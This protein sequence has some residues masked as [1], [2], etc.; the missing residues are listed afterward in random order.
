MH[1]LVCS[2]Y[3]RPG[4]TGWALLDSIA[5]DVLLDFAYIE[6]TKGMSPE[7]VEDINKQLKAL[8]PPSKTSMVEVELSD[9]RVIE[10]SEARLA[11]IREKH[12]A[13]SSRPRK[14]Q[15]VA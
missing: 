15:E 12:A 8:D 6:L 10:V 11:E 3:A 4:Q 2:G 5:L 13:M 7:Q 1:A 9:G 14:G